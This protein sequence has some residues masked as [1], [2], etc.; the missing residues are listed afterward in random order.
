MGMAFLVMMAKC[1]A[2]IA[3]VSKPH[4]HMRIYVRA[5]AH[6]HTQH[7]HSENL[8]TSKCTVSCRL[9]Q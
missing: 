6:K 4:M 3:K 5:R 2:H 7:T 1:T 9:Y 8:S